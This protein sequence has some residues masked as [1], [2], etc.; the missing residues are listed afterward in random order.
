DLALLWPRE[1]SMVIIPFP[2]SRSTVHRLG[3]GGFPVVAASKS[4]AS[5]ALLA[6]A[7]TPL[8][9]RSPDASPGAPPSLA[10]SRLAPTE[11]PPP[12]A[13]AGS[14][15]PRPGPALI[16]IAAVFARGPPLIGAATS[17]TCPHRIARTA[18]GE[19]GAKPRARS[20]S[21]K[22]NHDLLLSRG[23]PRGRLQEG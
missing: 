22:H 3:L 13:R 2:L 21:A 1:P 12:P 19:R 14:P 20:K 7:S 8:P 23:P 4:S 18:G 10:A 6:P 11:P 16:R 5:T 9:P 15:P 17:W